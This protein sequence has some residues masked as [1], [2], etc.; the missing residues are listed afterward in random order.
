VA[1]R[2]HLRLLPDGGVPVCQFNTEVVGNL[3]RQSFDEVWRSA[4]AQKS[5]DWVDACTGCWAEC[6]VVPNAVYSGDIWRG[7]L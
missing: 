4:A 1:L 3:L 5:R 7:A 6:E 2:S